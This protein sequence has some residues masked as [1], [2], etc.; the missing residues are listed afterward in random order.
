VVVSDAAALEEMRHITDGP[1]QATLAG[2]N[3]LIQTINRERA[4]DRV[5]VSLMQPASTLVVGGKEM[6]DLPP[7]AMQVLKQGHNGEH[8]AVV[9]ESSMGEWS[10]AMDQVVTGQQTLTISI[11]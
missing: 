5:F 3:E 11:R 10:V 9:G 4:N 8:T 2:L 7:S 1:G 6:P